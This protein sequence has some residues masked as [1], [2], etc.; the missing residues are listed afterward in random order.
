MPAAFKSLK[1]IVSLPSFNMAIRGADTSSRLTSTLIDDAETSSCTAVWSPGTAC[2]AWISGSAASASAAAIRKG[3]P[4]YARGAIVAPV[5]TS[6]SAPAAATVKSSPLAGLP[7]LIV[8]H[9]GTP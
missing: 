1:A 8:H 6:S 3:P 5:R 7:G 4:R 9:T 2:Q